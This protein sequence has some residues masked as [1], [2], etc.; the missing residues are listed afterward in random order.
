MS[1]MLHSPLTPGVI[2]LIIAPEKASPYQVRCFKIFPLVIE[3]CAMVKASREFQVFAK[4]VSSIW[5]LDCYYCYIGAGSSGLVA[6]LTAAEGGATVIVFEKMPFAGG[7]SNFPG[8]P[9]AVES[10]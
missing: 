4:P 5:N 6:V 2:P 9:S 7:T 3:D 10:K 8:G 1:H